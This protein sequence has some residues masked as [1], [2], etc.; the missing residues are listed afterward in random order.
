M[1]AHFRFLRTRPSMAPAAPFPPRL[2][3]LLTM[4]TGFLFKQSLTVGDGD[5]I[6]VRM[7]FGKSEESVAIA[8]VVDKGRL[9]RGLHPRHLG[10][11]DIAAQGLLIGGFEI[12]F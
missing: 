10:E 3:F 5:L 11:I 8:A 4:R 2:L 12:E 9:E 7:N 1:R 6:I